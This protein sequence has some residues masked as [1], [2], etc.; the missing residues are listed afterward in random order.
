M[1]PEW[2]SVLKSS[3]MSKSEVTSNP[4]AMLD[5]LDFHMSGG[6]HR[7]LSTTSLRSSLIQRTVSTGNSSSNS[8]SSPRKILPQTSQYSFWQ[9]AGNGILASESSVQRLM[10]VPS[11]LHHR[12][13]NEVYSVIKRIGHG[14]Y[15]SVYSAL[16]K[17]TGKRVA[18]KIVVFKSIPVNNNNNN[19][20]HND[21]ESNDDD[22]A[23]VRKHEIS[24][25]LNEMGLQSIS[26]HPNIVHCFE[27]YQGLHE[28][29]MVTELVV[30]VTLT[31]LLMK[32]IPFPESIVAFV[33]KKVLMALSFIH[34]QRR[35]HRDIKS[36]NILIGDDGTVKITDFGFATNL[37]IENKSKSS[38][39]GTPYWYYLVVVVVLVV[40]Y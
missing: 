5:V 1:P 22:D 27:A 11:F 39:A 30:G 35:I 19:N 24:I 7:N 3:G 16:H 38:I 37:T 23:N 18:L 29:C 15:G 40:P 13:Y 33:A 20:N 4:Q 12:D 32:S 8:N 17:T 25:L 28:F 31:D 2:E 21:N 34:S 26:K 14:T 9:P 6:I 10:D 36:D